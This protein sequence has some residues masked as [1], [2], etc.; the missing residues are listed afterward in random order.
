MPLSLL[1]SRPAARI[2]TARAIIRASYVRKG[3]E[4]HS[5]DTKV[6]AKQTPIMNQSHM[7][8]REGESAVFY[9]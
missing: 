9:P 7:I 5:A 8:V 6:T 3:R 1:K 2:H 4:Y